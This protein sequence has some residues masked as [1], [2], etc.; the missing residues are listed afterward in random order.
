MGTQRVTAGPGLI[1]S[2]R[3]TSAR[4]NEREKLY[5][6]RSENILQHVLLK[7]DAVN[8]ED[9]V[10]RGNTKQLIVDAQ[11]MLDRLDRMMGAASEAAFPSRGEAQMNA[12][13][14]PLEE[15][16]IAI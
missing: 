2:R 9:G 11:S 12:T 1:Q 7:V 6:E 13:V 4:V 14:L 16:G 3:L 5:D 15:H 10:L 8:A